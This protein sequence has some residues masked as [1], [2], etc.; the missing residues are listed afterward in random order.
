[1]NIKTLYFS[2]TG[3]T[4]KI[5]KCFSEYLRLN[6]N[7]DKESLISSWD[8]TLPNNRINTPEYSENDIVLIGVPVYAG[9]VPNILLNFLSSI[10]GNGAL[11]VAFV[12]YGNRNYDDALIELKDILEEKGFIVTAAGAFIGEHSFSKILAKDRPDSDD[13]ALVKSFA[14]AVSSKLKSANSKNSVAVP[15]E[16]PYRPY[17]RPKDEMG[18]PVDIRKVQ[19]KTKD[20][21]IDCKICSQ[22]CP[23]GS[24]SF[25]DV[26]NLIGI[27][28][29]CG[30]CEK[31]CPVSAK[32]FDDKDYLRH[33]VEL[34][35]ELTERKA[36]EFF[37]D[38]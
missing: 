5:I 11:A 38:L 23:V 17:Y 26:K 7:M 31:N 34:E 22:V 10:K 24:I 18:N 15:G 16:K 27:C 3:T 25:E 4:K 9:R 19:P 32:Y 37:V 13:L 35:I 8:F 6:L 28:I 21:C 33:K 12:L 36:P 20:A 1:M 29:K 14:E 30:A 2:P